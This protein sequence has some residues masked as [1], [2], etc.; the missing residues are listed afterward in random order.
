MIFGDNFLM[1]TTEHTI[2]DAI[3]ELLKDTR[4]IWQQHNVVRSE[5]IDI[6][7]SAGK[8]PDILVNEPSVSPVII[9]TEVLPAASVEDDAI[10]RLGQQLRPSG[11]RILSALAVRLPANLREH[12][13]QSLKKY[14]NGFS[15]FSVTYFEKERE[16]SLNV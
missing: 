10:Q 11:K 2:N 3:A 8:R 14:L 13:G 6:L 4:R 5:N 15:L 7:K 16:P 9:E 12:E 1:A